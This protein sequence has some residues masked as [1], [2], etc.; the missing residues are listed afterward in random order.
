MEKEFWTLNDAF[1]EAMRQNDTLTA[2]RRLYRM[3][4]IYPQITDNDLAANKAILHNA[5][6]LD[7]VIPAFNLAYFVPFA[8]KL[9]DSDWDGERSRDGRIIPSL[10]QRITNKLM[11][12]LGN[13]NDKYIKAVMPFFR[14]A[15][16]INPSNKDNLRHLAQLYVRVK[17]KTQAIKIYRRLLDKYHDGYLYGELAE[18]IDDQEEKKRLLC[19]AIVNTPREVFRSGYRYRLAEMLL[20]TNPTRA[21]YEIRKSLAARN[22]AKQPIPADVDRI[23]R[24][25]K[26]YTPVTQEEQE[27]WYWR[28]IS[29]PS[30]P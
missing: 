23:G 21:A 18:L 27:S 14:K 15:L 3:T 29:H 13:R 25:L 28:V 17:L 4:Q 1:K 6:A 2:R 24:I 8:M 5:L 22:K 12:N 16:Q 20:M 30:K 26:E 9:A 19:L 11:G 10:G 7:K